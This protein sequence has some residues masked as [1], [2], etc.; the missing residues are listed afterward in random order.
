[1]DLRKTQLKRTNSQQTMECAKN[2][3][4]GSKCNGSNDLPLLLRSLMKLT[5]LHST[6]LPRINVVKWYLWTR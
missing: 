6:I 4:G 1:M 2:Y 3:L 5:N